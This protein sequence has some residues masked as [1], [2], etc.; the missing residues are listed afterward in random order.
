MPKLYNENNEEVVEVPDDF[1]KETFEAS[2]KT[3]AEYNTL[4]ESLEL[5]E[6]QTVNDVITGLK[7][8]IK[9]Q[10]NPNW[11]EAREKIKRLE[12]LNSKLKEQGKKIDDNGK[13]VDTAPVYDPAKVQEEAKSVA[14]GVILDQRKTQLFNKYDEKQRLV[15]ED[16]Y[17]KLSAG[18]EMNL[19]NI[20]KIMAEAE[21]LSSPTRPISVARTYNNS[22]G[23]G[24]PPKPSNQALS[25]DAKEV[26]KE[27]GLTDEEMDG[28]N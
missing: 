17:N 19:E 4:K 25:E 14:I 22:A 2:Q 12:N 3:Q 7:N 9:E 21:T 15:V 23:G 28:I 5:K 20:D 11:S 13:I 10:T 8:D 18:Q 16:Y 27:M 6:G 24:L 26:G 1:N